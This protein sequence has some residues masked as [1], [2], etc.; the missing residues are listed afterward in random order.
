MKTLFTALALGLTPAPT[1]TPP[2]AP[3]LHGVR[4][5]P[6]SSSCPPCISD[7]TGVA[8]DD[9]HLFLP[10]DATWEDPR[11][12]ANEGIGAWLRAEVHITR[13]TAPLSVDVYPLS[14]RPFQEPGD[15]HVFIDHIE[16]AGGLLAV[17]LV[18]EA[19]TG[20]V[21]DTPIPPPRR[22]GLH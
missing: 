7:L 19:D 11:W 4:P 21:Y 13:G 1:A 12:L 2:D 22:A 16:T 10:A 3:Q 8:G 20:V 6:P 17:Q 14:L 15:D 5:Q 9:L 18:L